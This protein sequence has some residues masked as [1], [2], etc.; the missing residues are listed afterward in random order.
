MERNAWANYCL[1]TK[2]GRTVCPEPSVNN[3]Q[4]C[5]KSQ[6]SDDLNYI[7]AEA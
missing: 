3:Y 2:T 7:T 1:I 4:R 5:A 6:K